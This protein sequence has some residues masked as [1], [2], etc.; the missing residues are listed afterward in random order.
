MKK[1]IFLAF[2]A[3]SVTMASC[4]KDYTCTCDDTTTEVRTQNGNVTTTA[5]TSKS[6]LE[7]TGLKRKN[8]TFIDCNDKT[9]TSSSSGGSGTFAYTTVSTTESKCELK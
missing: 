3:L 8:K 5:S 7:V 4:R 1:I 2:V 9:T 6:N